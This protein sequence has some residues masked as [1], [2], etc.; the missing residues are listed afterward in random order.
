MKLVD[1]LQKTAGSNLTLKKQKK[2]LSNNLFPIPGEL[3]EAVRYLQSQMSEAPVMPGA[4]DVC[5]TGGSGMD[6][7][8]TSTISAFLLAACGVHVAK[9][10][11]NASSG[12]F[13]SFDLLEALGVPVN[14]SN[15]E[16]QLRFNKFN[17]A[18]LYARNYYAVMRH[19]APVRAELKQPTFFNILGPLLNPANVDKQIIGT[20]NIQYARMIADTAKILGRKRVIVVTGSDGLDEVTLCGTTQVVELADNKIKE[21]TI[22][23]SDF[24]IDSTVSYSEI[25]SN[26]NKKNI[27]I[28]EKI[29]K[30]SEKSRRADLV[31]INTALA[32]LLADRAKDLRDGYVIAKKIMDSKKGYEVLCNYR[33]PRVLSQIADNNSKR[34]F[35]I[36]EAFD[37]EIK[38]Q[39]VEYK[40][41]LIAEIKERSPSEGVLRPNVNYSDMAKIYTRSGASAIS[42]LTESDNFDGS[43]YKFSRARKSSSLPLL[44]KDF[45]LCSEHIDKAK[46]I[47][48]DMILL[49]VA[50]LDDP[51]LAKLYKHASKLGLQVIVEVHDEGELKRALRLQPKIIGVN[52]RNLHDFSIDKA[53]FEKLIA[54]IPNGVI[55]VAES[56][57]VNFK[58]IPN[59]YDGA[60]VGSE[61]MKHPF[62]GLKVKELSGMP[63][64]KLCGIR[65]VAQATLCERMGVDMIGINFVPQSRRKIS[66]EAAKN[67]TRQCKNTVTIGV[68]ENQPPA[69]VNKI[70]KAACVDAIQLSGQETD[71]KSYNY[72]LIKTLQPGQAK[73]SGAFMSILDGKKPG[74]GQAFNHSKIKKYETSLIAGGV[75]LATAKKLQASKQPL[76]FDIASGIETNGDIDR[77][78]IEAL[79]KLFA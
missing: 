41:G 63:L 71:L 10:G 18:F 51:E 14:L 48:A 8:N 39:I 29:L 17:L 21:Y 33:K 79:A 12:K 26:S 49:I 32:L 11:N 1:F 60:L 65:N 76:G 72:P 3:A 37:I 43:F 75:V 30:G 47:G 64:L 56:G 66:A 58:D 9:H 46:S 78:K 50:M 44:C 36:D 53:V 19:F 7:I 73:P 67:I 24:G 23:P 6:R 25:S 55:K 15:Q 59:G 45:I 57:I 52:S 38:H 54:F 34:S 40:G 70:A 68:F 31:L 4:I 74:S 77:T 61:I 42:V 62:P 13:G 27:D 5:G 69:E 22:S 16:L 20:P 28:A 2:F 35:S